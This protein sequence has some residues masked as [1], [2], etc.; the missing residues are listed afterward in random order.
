MDPSKLKNRLYELEYNGGGFSLAAVGR[1]TAGKVW[2][3]ATNWANGAPTFV[4]TDVKSARLLLA[5]RDRG[6]GKEI[7]P[8]QIHHDSA[9]Y[10]SMAKFS[11]ESESQLRKVI[12]QL[13]GLGPIV[14]LV[15]NVEGQFKNNGE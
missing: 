2:F 4:W 7:E 10:R 12:Q 13:K 15:D 11:S 8:E 6:K 9:F 3:A 1:D 14:I 5:E